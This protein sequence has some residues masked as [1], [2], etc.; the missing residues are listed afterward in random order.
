MYLGGRSA[1]LGITLQCVGSLV[2][3]A[4]GGGWIS[5]FKCFKSP[6]LLAAQ[7][8]MLSFGTVGNILSGLVWF[9]FSASGAFELLG[10]KTVSLKGSNTFLKIILFAW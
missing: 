1:K 10:E 3:I 4:R 8:V 9:D 7:G 2:S 6:F 5:F